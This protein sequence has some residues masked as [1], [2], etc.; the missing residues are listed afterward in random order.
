MPLGAWDFS[1][2]AS[3]CDSILRC[4]YPLQYCW[5]FDLP[6][7]L[8]IIAMSSPS[9]S[10]LRWKQ[11]NMMKGFHTNPKKPKP[12]K[13]SGAPPVNPSTRPSHYLSAKYP[14]SLLA[15]MLQKNQVYLHFYFF[16]QLILTMTMVVYFVLNNVHYPW[17][18][19]GE[20]Q[21]G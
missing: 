19:L 17:I 9:G 20:I 3:T 1:G 2:S 16:L 21:R 18:V 10:D 15:S 6:L 8:H 7:L 11:G 12:Q 13:N 14:K 5:C 4:L